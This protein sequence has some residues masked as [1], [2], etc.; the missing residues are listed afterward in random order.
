[1]PADVLW[2]GSWK[3]A[4]TCCEAPQWESVQLQVNNQLAFCVNRANYSRF[5]AWNPT[6][7]AINAELAPLLQKHVAPVRANYQLSKRFEDSVSWD[8]MEICI[9]TEFNDICEP[10]FFLNRVLPWYQGGHF[11]CGWDGPKL[12][13]TWDGVIPPGRLIVF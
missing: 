8:L 5:A 2:V 10:I 3:E 11:P 13:E 1:M 4:M 9:E 7:A 6:V 12:E